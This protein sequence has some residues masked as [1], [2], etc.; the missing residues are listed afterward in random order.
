MSS[1]KVGQVITVYRGDNCVR[2]FHQRN[3][4]GYVCRLTWVKGQRLPGQRIAEFTASGTDV[5]AYHKS[6][7]PFSPTF[8]HIGTTAATADGVQAMGFYNTFG[9]GVAFVGTDIYFQPFGLAYS[10]H[11]DD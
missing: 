7:S 9:F 6:G 1:S 5:A 2:Q 3:R 4:F 10:F 11:F 8:A